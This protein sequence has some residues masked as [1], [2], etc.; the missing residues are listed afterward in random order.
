MLHTDQHNSQV[1]Q[2]MTV[3][4][5]LKNN[6]K[7]NEGEDLPQEMLVDLFNSI[8]QHE[9]RIQA[10]GNKYD[11]S[12]AQWV[13]IVKR[14]KS[15]QGILVSSPMQPVFDYDMFTMI[16]GPTIAAVSVVFDQ[17]EDESVVQYTVDGFLSIANLASV[18]HF[19]DA[20]DN[21]VISLCKF[22]TTL[23]PKVRGSDVL[24]EDSKAMLALVTMFCI[25]NQYGDCMRGSWRS[26]IDCILK[27]H[28][29]HL[30]PDK[31]TDM[32][33]VRDTIKNATKNAVFTHGG[34]QMSILQSVSNFLSF[35]SMKQV[36]E[37]KSEEEEEAERRISTY[38]GS[39]HIDEIFT[40]SKF[41][42]AESL[43][44]LVSALVWSA[45]ET[46]KGIANNEEEEERALLCL[47][48]LIS[49]TIRNRD[50]IDL[51]WNDTF[52]HLQVIIDSATLLSPLVEKAVFGL[53]RI[54]Q[55]LVPY[56]EDIADELLQSLQ[57]IL[58]LDA[59]VADILASHLF[60]ELLHLVKASAL[61][62]K[63]EACWKTFCALLKVGAHHLEAAPAGF[64]ILG[65]LVNKS[66]INKAN[67]VHLLQG[68]TAFVE[69]HA[70]GEDQSVK[71]LEL[72]LSVSNTV[73]SWNP[74]TMQSDLF[75]DWLKIVKVFQHG[76]ADGR[77]TVRN[78]ACILLQQ[79]LLSASSMQFSALQVGVVM[80]SVVLAI[81]NDMVSIVK[82]KR[83][84]EFPEMDKTARIALLMLSKCILQY[85]PSLV[86]LGDFAK[87]W[88]DT[89]SIFDLA[90]TCA[91]DELSEAAP[92]TLKNLLLVM[93]T[94]GILH[95]EWTDDQGVNLWNVT[96]QHARA[97]SANLTPSEYNL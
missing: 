80:K 19:C 44:H 36:P 35:D 47:D 20:I 56:K 33:E 1:K 12:H 42:E 86:E 18:Y 65:L 5:F 92:E 4:D 62:I 37:S 61:H 58:K 85:L 9:I 54:C 66:S 67:L 82:K 71:A 41:L 17:A 76:C 68:V 22:V 8:A 31:V 93:A 64:E 97:I 10:D 95:R 73:K 23:N 77:L 29:L 90:N 13:D 51:L 28:R 78:Q 55:R 57:L 74:T 96:W 25:V 2:K 45:G 53:L 21:L 75:D 88:L 69:G 79:V 60:A 39:C 48:L 84:H 81:V 3:E 83:N 89:L 52:Q 7:I 16:W 70:G 11:L 46:P 14:S 94:Q 24:I 27:L 34:N 30:L 50:R 38:I 87:I 40:E 91:S 32:E 49:T 72:L 26:V 6:R 15:H 59:K 43:Q 63:T